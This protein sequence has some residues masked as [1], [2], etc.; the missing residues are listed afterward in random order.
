GVRFVARRE[1]FQLAGLRADRRRVRAYLVPARLV[2]R[3]GRIGGLTFSCRPAWRRAGGRAHGAARR[4]LRVQRG[5][6]P[7][8]FRRRNRGE[9]GRFGDLELRDVDA[10]RAQRLFELDGQ[11]VLA[12][13]APADRVDAYEVLALR[14]VDDGCAH[15][16]LAA[17]LVD[18]L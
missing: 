15:A 18:L 10:D 9:L 16:R 11:L 12:R 13:I 2:L 1:V 5:L 14:V 3:I 8:R 17:L 6:V 4:G 7:P